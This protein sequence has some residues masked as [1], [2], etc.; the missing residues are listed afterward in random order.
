MYCKHIVHTRTLKQIKYSY[1]IHGGSLYVLYE[2]EG[3][4]ASEPSRY[5][6]VL[7]CCPSCFGDRLFLRWDNIVMFLITLFS[8]MLSIYTSTSVSAIALG[9]YYGTRTE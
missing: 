7:D 2:G 1:F 5:C 6:Y 4:I 9:R 8:F 3:V